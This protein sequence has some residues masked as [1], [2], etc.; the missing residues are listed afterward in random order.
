MNG[1]WTHVRVAEELRVNLD[2]GRVDENAGYG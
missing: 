1:F 2:S